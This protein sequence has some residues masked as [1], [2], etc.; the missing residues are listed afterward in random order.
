MHKSLMTIRTILGGGS[1]LNQAYVQAVEV[2][3]R[4]IFPL[5]RQD[6]MMN[7]ADKQ[8][9]KLVQLELINHLYV[10]QNL[11]SPLVSFQVIFIISRFSE[12]TLK[13]YSTRIRYKIIT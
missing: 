9:I 1:I 4:A 2:Q 11:G 6:G 7:R 3:T 12:Y 8:A 5:W 13:I 10:F